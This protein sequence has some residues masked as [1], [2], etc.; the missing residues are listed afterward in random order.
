MPLEIRGEISSVL[1]RR[2]LSPQETEKVYGLSYRQQLRLI[3]SGQLHSVKIMGRRQDGLAQAVLEVVLRHAPDFDPASVEMRPSAK[4]NYLSLTCTIRAVSREPFDIFRAA[5]LELEW[6]IV[7]R[8]RRSAAPGQLELSL[9]ELQ[10]ELY[11][12]AP[13]DFAEHAQLRA[14]AMTIRD[15]QAEAGG[16]SAE[17]WRKIEQLLRDSWRSLHRAVNSGGA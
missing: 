3:R 9:A 12:Q 17:D 11:G 15:D 7:H 4:G 14:E 10:A 6:W 16:V 1:E 2:C 5:N 13:E 8:E